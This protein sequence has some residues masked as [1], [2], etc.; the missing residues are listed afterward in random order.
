MSFKKNSA[1]LWLI[2]PVGLIV[3]AQFLGKIGATQQHG[4]VNFFTA[5]AM[6]LMFIRSIVWYVL[7]QRFELKT[8]FPFLSLAYIFVLG[9][10]C[11]YFQESLSFRQAV[12][13]LF[14]MTGIY[15]HTMVEVKNDD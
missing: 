6:A 15:L 13:I 7:L 12:G 14:I 8:A 9:V 10:G 4:M 11:F 1:F 5:G 3:A 2:V